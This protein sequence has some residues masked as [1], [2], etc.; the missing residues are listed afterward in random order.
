MTD[1]EILTEYPLTSIKTN[2][3]VYILITTAQSGQTVTSVERKIALV[4]IKSIAM[5][6]HRDDWIVRTSDYTISFFSQEKNTGS[7]LQHL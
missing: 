6:N 5:S 4:T 1:L 3:A 7:E 2:K